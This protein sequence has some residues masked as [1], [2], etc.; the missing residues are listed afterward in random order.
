MTGIKGYYATE[1][2]NHLM[3]PTEF[4]VSKPRYSNQCRNYNEHN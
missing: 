4:E 3:E 1:H 2:Y